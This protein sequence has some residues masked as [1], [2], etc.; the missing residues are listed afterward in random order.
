M[1]EGTKIFYHLSTLNGIV[2]ELESIGVKIDEDKALRL[3]WSLPSSY[4]YIKHIL[5]YGKD[6]LNFEEVTSKIIV[7]EKRMKCE[8]RNSIDSVMV[9]KNGSDGRKKYGKNVTCWKCGK[10]RH[11]KKNCPG[12][13]SLA[14]GSELDASSVSLVRGRW[15]HSCTW[16]LVGIDARCVV[17]LCRWLRNFQ[18]NPTWKKHLKVSARYFDICRVL[19]LRTVI[20]GVDNEVEDVARMVWEEFNWIQGS[21]KDMA[22]GSSRLLWSKPQR[23]WFKLN[24][25]AAT[26]STGDGSIGGLIRDDRGACIAAFAMPVSFPN[27][28]VILESAF[29][30]SLSCVLHILSVN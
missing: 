11:V 16:A 29:K 24:V 4:E 3:I 9:T 7:E 23:N 18:E 14:N 10:S 13:A 20:V 5:M 1:N 19:G 6:T 2:S 15:V 8:S 12:G 26:M 30:L 27:E 22:A 28:P 21:L 25:D 17:E